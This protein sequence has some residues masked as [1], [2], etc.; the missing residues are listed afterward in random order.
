MTVIGLQRLIV[1]VADLDRSRALYRDVLG[2]TE[3][4]A[5]GDFSTL[6]VPGTTTEIMLHQRPPTAGLAGVAI[7]FRVDDVDAVTA[8]AEKAG[9]AVID[10]PEDQPWGERQ[11]VLTDPDGHVFC[12][13]SI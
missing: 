3:K 2:L 1:S 11:A 8:A 12:L 4:S 9:A 6:T 10:A 5:F 7:S 13:V